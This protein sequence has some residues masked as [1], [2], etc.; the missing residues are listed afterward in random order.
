MMETDTTPG[1]GAAKQNSESALK[2]PVPPSRSGW[3]KTIL[4][5]FTA[6]ELYPVVLVAAFLRFYGLA[7]TEFDSDQAA[8]WNMTRVALAHGLI[9]AN[10]NLASIGTVNPPAFLYIL[11]P[12]ALF[13]D[14]PLAGA[15]L[16]ALLNVIG[17]I[18]TYAFTRRYFGRLAG[19]VAA[20]LTATASIMLLYS[21]FIWQPN[22]LPPLLVLYMLA[23]FWGA[24]E[25]RAGWLAPAL[26]LLGLAMQLSGSSIYLAP[27]LVVAL[28]LGYKT[29]RWRDLALGV[30]LLALI[31]ST[32][33]VW[34]AATGYADL[35]LLLGASGKHA[36]IDSTAFSDYL[37]FLFAYAT[38]PTDPH[39]LF[40]RI[41]PLM[42]LHRWVMLALIGAS[43]VLLA[44]GLFWERVEL[45]ADTLHIQT[46]ARISISTD[47][48]TWRQVWEHWNAFIDSPQ[49]RGIL[50]LL[51]WQLLPLLLLSRHSIILQV[52][53]FLVLMPGPFILIGLLVSQVANW[54]AS[55]FKQYRLARKL[56]PALAVLL[57]L[58][59]T[60][61]SAAWL[62]DNTDGS[63][64]NTANYNTLYDLQHAVQA[65]DLLARTHHFEHVYI[66]AD[67]RTNDAFNYLAQDMQTPHTVI[68]SNTSHCLLLPDASLGPAVMLFGPTETLD[69]T[70]LQH[71][72]TASLISE[73]SRL[74][75]TP[76]H[77]YLVQPL[78]RATGA[79]AAMNSLALDQ[80]RATLL[81]WRNPDAPGQPVEHVLATVW[82]NLSLRPAGTGDWWTYHFATQ[83]AAG[84][85]RG[86]GRS[87]T[88][89]QLSSLAPGERL[90]VPFDLSTGASTSSAAF[91]INGTITMN[92]PYILNYGPLHF[93][94][95][96]E[97][98]TRLSTFQVTA[99]T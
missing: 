29:V 73:P 85:T 38:P 36:V 54:C 92:T 71:F 60:L 25:R 53:Y 70:L 90:L 15:I 61:G 88:D 24:V 84:S 3:R 65:A 57:I 27:A 96:R 40:T 52:H 55:F 4:T 2:G 87:T 59:Q 44:L 67:A 18:L 72:T 31:F 63:Q 98:A 28:V 97:Q 39:L 11:M 34:E 22:I 46:S 23:L 48:S 20:S 80:S 10:G 89:C 51:T 86:Q 47:A 8:L 16:M 91:S 78:Q 64:A 21:R 42:H 76:F 58:A 79:I 7:Y 17:V 43:F 74:G 12:A 32:Y 68:E 50:L 5:W 19:F 83:Y 49:R 66:D 26:L 6:W 94:T 45:M 62:A 81:N 37:R 14:N 30:L 95:L 75:G 13:T 69:E 99:R 82:Q 9:P 35:P 77:I 93:Q 1:I 41:F 33:M 56:V